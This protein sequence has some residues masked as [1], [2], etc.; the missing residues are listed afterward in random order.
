MCTPAI[1]AFKRAYPDCE[2]DFLTEHPDVLAGNLN[3]TRLLAVDKSK[4]LN[5]AY[6]CALVKSIRGR[7]YD[8]VVDFL[9]NPRSAY[10]TF[11]SGASLRL[12]YGFGH[13]KWAYNIVPDKS[14][15]PTYAAVDRLNLLRK[16]GVEPDGIKLEFSVSNIDREWVEQYLPMKGAGSFISISPVS[17]REHKRW[18]LENF[19]RLAEL[20]RDE[21]GAEIIILAGPGEEEYA[22]RMSAIMNTKP[23]V[24]RVMSLAH[25]GAIFERVSLHVGNDNGPKHIAVACGAPTFTI[26]GTQDPIS[27]TYPDYNRHSWLDPGKYCAECREK[28]HRKNSR[29]IELIPLDDVWNEIRKFARRNSRVITR[30]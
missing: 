27:W 10:Y 23:L 11:L 8:L 22:D 7:R 29:C 20:L 9:A 1:R 15:E 16:I 19:A 24:P 18:P 5:V 3:M 25:L 28:R 26:F 14:V 6:Q 17:R 2:L 4:E 30:R 13:R 21:L 12:S